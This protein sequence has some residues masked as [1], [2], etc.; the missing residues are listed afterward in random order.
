MQEHKGSMEA[1]HMWQEARLSNC[2]Y[3]VQNNNDGPC[4]IIV[5]QG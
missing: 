2:V 1:Q 5:G 3:A 4:C